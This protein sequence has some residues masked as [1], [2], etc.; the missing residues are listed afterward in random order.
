VLWS[1]PADAQD[2][3]AMGRYLRW[4]E[5]EEH[6]RFEGYAALHAWSARRT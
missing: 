2:T 4:L 6:A 3:C 1:P 5:Q